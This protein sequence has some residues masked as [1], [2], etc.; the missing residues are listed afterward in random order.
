MRKLIILTIVLVMAMA[1]ASFATYT[2]VVTMGNNN[3]ILLD[4]A[5]VWLY[6]SRINQ[7]PN[8][9]IARRAAS[10]GTILVTAT[11]SIRQRGLP[12]RRISQAA[13]PIVALTCCTGASSG[14]LC[15]DSVWTTFTIATPG[16][17]TR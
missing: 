11:M 9:A 5:N 2:R 4:D 1:T 12:V 16:S 14:R 8:L 13:A 17:R 6:P 15:S 7:Y 3:N 10:A